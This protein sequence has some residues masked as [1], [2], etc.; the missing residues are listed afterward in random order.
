MSRLSHVVL[1]A[2]TL[3]M[4]LVALLEAPLEAQD[5]LD[6]KLAQY[7]QESDPVRKARMLA[8]LGDEQVALA[9]RQL[10]DG[11]D[12]DCLQTLEQYRDEVLQTVALLKT[13]GVNAEASPKGFKELQISVRE[14]IRRIQ[15]LII[16]LPADKRP[17][18]REVPGDLTKAEDDLIDALFPRQR[19]KNPA[20]AHP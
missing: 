6:V 3:S 7:H 14:T 8:N 13:T 10:K 15:D 5:R 2:M 1:V 18:F 12:V 16:A 11:N 4:P 9:R 19:D 17:F 20:T